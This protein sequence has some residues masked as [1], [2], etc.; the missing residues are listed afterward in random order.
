[1]PPLLLKTKSMNLKLKFKSKKLPKNSSLVFEGTNIL[2]SRDNKIHPLPIGY[3]TERDIHFANSMK[4]PLCYNSH[5]NL[6]SIQKPMLPFIPGS[7][8]E[9]IH[10]EEHKVDV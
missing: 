10:Q 9:S 3:M 1:M 8:P 4:P 6:N 7:L 2:D 5:R